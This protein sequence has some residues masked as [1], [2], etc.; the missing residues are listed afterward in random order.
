[1]KTTL[2]IPAELLEDVMRESK[3]STKKD[4]VL[5]ALNEYLAKQKLSKIASQFGTFS[6]FADPGA[7]E[8][9]REERGI[10]PG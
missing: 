3:C 8:A 6:G 5:L 10:K 2:D 7:F 9:M 1:M 4:A